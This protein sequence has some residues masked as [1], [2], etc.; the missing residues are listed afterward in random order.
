MSYPQKWHTYLPGKK[1]EMTDRNPM[2]QGLRNP[3]PGIGLVPGKSMLHTDLIRKWQRNAEDPR[4]AVN[5]FFGGG[6]LINHSALPGDSSFGVRSAC[7]DY[8]MD[9][10]PNEIGV[11]SVAGQCWQDYA[12]HREMQDDFYWQGIVTTE[13]RLTPQQLGGNTYDPNHG[14]ATARAGTVSV[15][16]NGKFTFYPGN[17]ICYQWPMTYLH[18]NGTKEFNGGSTINQLARAGTVPTQFKPELVPFDPTDFTVQLSAA[19]THSKLTK[20]EGGISN[21]PF[22]I[23]LPSSSARNG[24]ISRW[25]CIQDEAAAYKFGLWGIF[26]GMLETVLARGLIPGSV[27]MSSEDAYAAVRGVIENVGLFNV[28]PTINTPYVHEA[29]ANVF[30]RNLAPGTEERTPALT[31]FRANTGKEIW[32]IATEYPRTNEARYARLR[33][34]AMEILIHGIAGS[35]Y[36]KT[37]TIIG[38]A[39]N[40]AAPADTLDGLWGHFAL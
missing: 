24:A 19:F 22:E 33:V 18:P 15:I 7:N 30:L 16:N 8:I 27:A 21:M 39:M 38:K 2:L 25:Q 9:G 12:S 6:D 3:V 40:S 20:E 37:S 1:K 4:R 17:L 32:D 35:W 5:S 23:L 13:S 26:A 14:Y 34:H 10:E 11:V 36:S 29:L 28:D 31:D